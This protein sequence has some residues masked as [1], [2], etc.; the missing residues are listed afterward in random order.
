MKILW[1]MLVVI[2]CIGSLRANDT[3]GISY[4]GIDQGLSNN[5]VTC[6]YQDHKGFMW[7]GTYDG[8]NRYDGYEFKV[9]M[10]QPGDSTS[11]HFNR[12]TA[13]AEDFQNN[14]WIGT[15]DGMSVCNPLTF[16]FS[17][18]SYT[19]FK[20]GESK[21]LTD[22]ISGIKADKQGNVF[23][24]SFT[25]GL[26]VYKK[27]FKAAVQIPYAGRT[28]YDVR[29]VEVDE[30]QKKVWLVIRDEGLCQYD[31]I[32]NTIRVV[33]GSI[34]SANCL[35]V[36]DSGNIFVGTDNGVFEFNPGANTFLP[37]LPTADKIV[38]LAI[39]ANKNLWMAS[40]GGGIFI[41]HAH[42]GKV[43][44]LQRNE[45]QSLFSS[46]AVYDI[47]QDKEGR[48]WIG[49]LRGGIDI[50]DPQRSRFK[51]VRHDP[52][53]NNSLVNNFVSAFCEDGDR[54][55]WIGTD[56]GG[57]SCWNREKNSFVNFVYRP[58]DPHSI[59]SNLVT[60]L[61]TDD[62]GDVWVSTW[63]GGI[64]RWDRRSRSF[65]RFRCINTSSNKEEVN[66]WRLYEDSKRNLWA[67]TLLPG[68]LYR[69][70]GQKKAFELFDK[71]LNDIL[72]IAEDR[73]GEIWMGEHNALVRID[74]D[75]KNH[76]W[77]TI[78]DRVRAIHEDKGGRFWLG[79]ED[80]GLLLFNRSDGSFIRLT[81]KDGLCSNAILSI[82]ED[83]SGNLWISTFK[84]LSKFNPVSRKFTNYS[85]S[86]NLQ[87]DQFNYN[88]A[89]S[90][91]SGELAFG[92]IRGFSIFYPKEIYTN[93]T[94]PPVFISGIKINNIPIE[95]DSACIAAHSS[96]EVQEIKLPFNKATVS[97]D[98]VSLE[99][100]SPDKINYAYRLEGR[101]EGWVYAGKSRTVNYSRLHE[102]KYI[103]RV[104]ATDT[105]GAWS[106]KEQQLVIIVLPPWYRTWWAYLMYIVTA[107][108]MAYAYLRYQ[109]QKTRLAYEVEWA[110]KETERE[111]DLN[112]KKLSF[113]TN[114]S[115][116]FR[117]PL[118]LIIDPLKELLHHPDKA[119]GVNDLNIVY[120]NA[121]RL[122]SL[123]DQLLLFRKADTEADK[124]KITK[125]NFSALCREVFI[126]FTQQA[127]ARNIN[128]EFACD[129]AAIELYL[130]R[131]KM[132]IVL[133][134][135]ISNA[136]KFTPE[137]GMV[138]FGVE[139]DHRSIKV[140]IRDSGCGIEDH[141]GDR[142]FDRFYQEK[143][144][145]TS[146]KSGFGIGLY[147]VKQFV[148]A[149]KGVIS[150]QSKVNEGTQF[151]LV[152]Q[153]GVDHLEGLY[154]HEEMAEN[155]ML[156]H[157]LA[158]D[159]DVAHVTGTS[160]VAPL[161]AEPNEIFTE[162]KTVLIV[163][164]NVD[165]RRYLLQIFKEQFIIYEAEDGEAGWQLALG[166][167]PDVIIS[168]VVMNGMTGVELCRK[169]KA[170]PSLM[171][172]PVI[173]LTASLSS[174]IKLKG[175]ECGAD[176]YITKP[177]EKE[178]LIA[179][180]DNILRRRNTLQQYFFERITLQKNY[181]RIPAVYK[182]FLE[183]CITVVENN[184]DNEQFS[185]KVLVKEMNMS[186]SSLYKK[187]KATSGQSI[188]A[189]IRLIRLRR[190][191]VLLLSKDIN[192]GEA[193]FEVGLS[194]AKYFRRQFVRVFG[195]PPSEYIRKY[196]GSFSK[197]FNVI[198][199]RG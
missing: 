155:P 149:H 78:G 17:I 152:L 11:L 150:Y 162:K 51:T 194:D 146:S 101:D 178:L 177:F 9:F 154:I 31:Y 50:I 125:G 168:D 15:T 18:P 173:L 76:T 115:H 166:H 144:K 163:D 164:D 139:E 156:L 102:G 91:R 2:G 95:A 112:E 132:E 1:T 59:G 126:C 186:H 176:D 46:S 161:R 188:N 118:T 180:V 98:F 135:L 14:L 93:R 107:V 145:Y 133:F 45:R 36:D 74:R 183:K 23:I 192:I 113:F 119:S 75:Q 21:K 56:G 138:S 57:L 136:L 24:A 116:E 65:V 159:A 179:R 58:D 172:V 62:K 109:A 175:I 174:E 87:S 137:G 114:I 129:N 160:R 22:G 30:K 67:S 189:F 90:L 27:G 185:I 157:E 38:Q 148:D 69:W 89:L 187:V 81:E 25:A 147:L 96:D 12:V 127:K 88:A 104:K 92:G 3:T 34:R 117:S 170:E 37:I 97:F 44:S 121:R 182:E 108:A 197:E 29:C 54:N 143:N 33:N 191:A 10:K 100:T 111:K 169:V 84:G 28:D 86:D 35:K 141:V 158:G 198:E 20:T 82:L 167:I 196:K 122:L 5:S 128:Y 105:D 72:V 103:F 106:G 26:I 71:R 199:Y 41:L 43:T 40:D 85:Q 190:A 193:A 4:L 123:V 47:Y 181:T 165:I 39:L 120:R 16:R 13:I 55:I 48:I 171:H 42:T 195:M 77:Y 63:Y 83:A 70:S 151:T 80:G 110:R 49:T 73:K 32:T 60:G 184:L 130:D 64:S 153:K 66:G 52:S 131:E 140:R 6:I 8:L 134:N 68:G 7:F 79:T 53:N 94:V 124:L 61:V 99:Y 19:S 142:L